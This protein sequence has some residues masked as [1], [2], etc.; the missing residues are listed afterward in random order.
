[1]TISFMRLARAL[2]E[3]KLPQTYNHRKIGLVF[4]FTLSGVMLFANVYAANFLFFWKAATDPSVTAYGIY[5]RTGDSSY[6]MIDEVSVQ[7]L[8]TP[9]NPSYLVTGLIDGNTYWFAATSI[10][11]S[12]TESNFY[13]QTCITVNGQ[14][15]E[16]TDNNENG[17]TVFI[18]CFITAAGR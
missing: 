8:D 4:F 2:R 6:V 9:A 5:Q 18:S 7:D 16:C 11:S 10:A 3:N 12:G 14:I 1:M 13:N 17:T 15:I